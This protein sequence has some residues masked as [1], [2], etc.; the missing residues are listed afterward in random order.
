MR[1]DAK[2]HGKQEHDEEDR[3]HLRGNL[4]THLA[5]ED[6]SQQRAGHGAEAE[7]AEA[8]CAEPIADTQRNE[9]SQL[10][11][12]AQRFNNMVP[13]VCSCVWD[14]VRVCAAWQMSAYFGR[15]SFEA[16]GLIEFQ[17]ALGLVAVDFLDIELAHEV[18][19]LLRQ[20]LSRH[21][22]REARRI[23]DDEVGRDEVR[24]VLAAACRSRR[25]LSGTYSQSSSS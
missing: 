17:P 18:D 16:D 24:A 20:H 10:R 21:H 8:Y 7:T 3:L 6:A 12:G 25:P 13:C 9:D 2:A 4:D 14:A 22:D 23:G 1:A 11:I 15:F 19:G 5:D